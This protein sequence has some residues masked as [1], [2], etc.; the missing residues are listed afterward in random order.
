[1]ANP[2]AAA[3]DFGASRAQS[4]GPGRPALSTECRPHSRLAGC[5]LA[6][7]PWLARSPPHTASTQTKK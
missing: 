5:W 1:M 3:A 7:L 2:A 6:C 4:T